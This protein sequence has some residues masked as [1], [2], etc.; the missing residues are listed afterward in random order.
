MAKLDF[1]EFVRTHIGKK[2]GSGQCVAGYNEYCY[3]LGITP[4]GGNAKDLWN[5]GHQDGC[6]TIYSWNE[7]QKGDIIIWD[8]TLGFGYGHVAM[9]DHWSNGVGGAAVVF[10]QNQGADANLESGGPFN[11]ISIGSA[12]FSGAFR[13]DNIKGNK[14]LWTISVKDGL[15]ISASVQ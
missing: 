2:Y 4:N 14:T 12:G 11:F 9:F 15:I 7:L 5:G 1:D 13:P 10:G 3:W 6:K 8:G